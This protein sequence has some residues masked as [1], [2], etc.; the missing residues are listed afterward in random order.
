MSQLSAL[1]AYHIDNGLPDTIFDIHAKHFRRM[2]DGAR[3]LQPP[4]RKRIRNPISRASVI[5]LSRNIAHLP[6]Q[7]LGLSAAPK[8]DL[9]LTVAARVAFAGFLQVGNLHTQLPTLETVRSSL[10]LR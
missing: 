3:R 2:V 9:N 10:L 5:T 1:R 4:R 7:P 8:N 6:A